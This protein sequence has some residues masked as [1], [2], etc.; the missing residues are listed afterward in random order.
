MPS[1]ALVVAVALLECGDLDRE[2]RRVHRSGSLAHAGAPSAALAAPP[3]RSPSRSLTGRAR[4]RSGRGRRGRPGLGG[5]RAPA[6][7]AASAVVDQLRRSTPPP[8]RPRRWR[9]GAPR[10]RPRR[11]AGIGGPRRRRGA[12]S[13]ASRPGSRATAAATSGRELALAEV[14]AHGLAGDGGVAEHA[15]EVVAQLEGLA[16]RHAV[17]G[18]RAGE[19]VERAR[20]ARRRGAAAAR[21]CTC[22]TCTAR[23]ARPARGRAR[24]LAVPTRSRYWPTHSS[25]RSSSKIG[26]AAGGA[27][28][29]S[30][31]A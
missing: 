31:S 26:R 22:P 30:M 28:A 20:R 5:D 4:R 11:C 13:S 1:T 2:R 23:C 8:R 29:K 15:E 16:E 21:R 18:E 17:R 12:S 19:V 14:V 25:M 10:A 9:R 27:V 7:S 3:R 24:R 6:A